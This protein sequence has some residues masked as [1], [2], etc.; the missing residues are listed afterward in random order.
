MNIQS[1]NTRHESLL[2]NL[3]PVRDHGKERLWRTLG[4]LRIQN[5]SY[6]SL[7]FWCHVWYLQ[8]EW[9]VRSVNLST[10]EKMKFRNVNM[11][12]SHIANKNHTCKLCVLLLTK[13]YLASVYSSY[14]HMTKLEIFL[15]IW[16]CQ[17]LDFLWRE[18]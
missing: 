17:S 7:F 10:C 11:K 4:S 12:F 6:S 5:V 1:G 16:F 3:H 13:E 9:R 8:S 2:R 15:A 18:I 14:E